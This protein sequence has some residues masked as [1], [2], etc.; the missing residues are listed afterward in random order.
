MSSDLRV[1]PWGVLSYS[2]EIQQECQG[3][4]HESFQ[5]GNDRMP[6]E[7]NWR[8]LSGKAAETVL[9]ARTRSTR[10]FEFMYPCREE[11]ETARKTI[12]SAMMSDS[13]S[14]MSRRHSP[15]TMLGRGVTGFVQRKPIQAPAITGRM[16]VW[17]DL[18][19]RILTNRT[20]I[21]GDYRAQRCKRRSQKTLEQ[22]TNDV[23]WKYQI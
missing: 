15:R 14:S 4:R 16:S 21:T 13:R 9:A 18:L 20:A 5:Q 17:D 19:S 6:V 7:G 2:L 1:G 22:S 12:A 11:T 3:L 23:C 10:V 8:M